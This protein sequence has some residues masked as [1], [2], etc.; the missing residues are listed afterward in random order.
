MTE[1]PIQQVDT[2]LQAGLQKAESADA[3][4]HARNPNPLELPEIRPNVNGLEFDPIMAEALKLS[5][6]TRIN[7]PYG[8]DAPWMVSR[9]ADIREITSDRRFSRAPLVDEV[10]IARLMPSF[11]PPP[12]VVQRQDDP[13]ASDMRKAMGSGITHRQMMQ[14]RPAVSKMVS[15]LLDAIADEPGPVDLFETFTGRLPLAVMAELTGIPESDCDDIRRWTRYLFSTREDQRELTLQAEHEIGGYSAGLVKARIENP[16]NDLLS[17]MI[18]DSDD[19]FTFGELVG[20]TIQLICIGI[21]PSNSLLSNIFYLLLTDD[22]LATVRKDPT[23]ID[24]SFDELCRFSPVIQG[25]G[26]PL[27]AAT[28]V[29]FHGAAI[30][31]GDTVVYSYTSG[32]RD[33]EAFDDPGELDISRRNVQH[34]TFGSGIHACVAEHFSKIIVSSSVRAFFTRFPVATLATEE[35]DWDNG[36]IW[37]FPVALPVS[38]HG[39]RD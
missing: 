12:E 1:C 20:M 38:L 13:K 9:A 24:Q 36:T 3:E 14:L 27:V 21:S 32:N 22:R 5:S 8:H 10:P 4:V 6:V 19:K 29:E 39:N 34:F 26:P 31:R 11:V 18:A 28:D 30:K 37:R 7:L 15:K 16:G 2:T 23:K 33:P 35:I 17:H 25:F